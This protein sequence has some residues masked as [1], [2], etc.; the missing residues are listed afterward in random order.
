MLSA[1]AVRRKRLIRKPHS[2][3]P[4]KQPAQ[5]HSPNPPDSFTGVSKDPTWQGN[6]DSYTLGV[7][8]LKNLVADQKNIWISPA[9]L[10]WADGSWL[11][12]FAAVTAGF[13]ATDR[14]VPPALSTNTASLNRYVTIS[15][16]GL[17]SMIGAGGGLFSMEQDFPRRPPKGDGPSRR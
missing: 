2:L 4:A 7:T 13:F 17:Y 1:F 9:H 10:H 11:F 3:L 16:Y 5:M 12:P 8:F 14:A 15:N 6:D